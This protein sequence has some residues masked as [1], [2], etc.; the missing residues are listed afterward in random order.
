MPIHRVSQKTPTVPIGSKFNSLSPHVTKSRFYYQTQKRPSMAIYGHIRPYMAIYGHIWPC[1]AIYGH[2]WQCLAMHGHA[3]PCMA[4][5]GHIWPCLAMHGHFAHNGHFDQNGH[6]DQNGHFDQ[7]GHSSSHR[8]S[9]N[10][11]T[12]PIGSKFN[13]LSPHVTKSRF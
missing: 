2:I 7:N 11:P 5:Y 9:Q 8:A 4:I 6:S 13:S 1:M 12:V 3:W 10:T